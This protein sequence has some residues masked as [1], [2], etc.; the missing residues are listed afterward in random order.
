[1]S[2]LRQQLV[3]SVAEECG[4]VRAVRFDPDARSFAAYRLHGFTALAGLLDA[5]TLEAAKAEATERWS[6][7]RGDRLGI[8]E[9][10]LEEAELFPFEKQPFD[11]LHVFAVRRSEPL[12]WDFSRDLM[13]KVPVYRYSLDLICTIDLKVLGA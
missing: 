8:R 7:D 6:W 13:R 1:M 3:R 11:R 9:R 4:P 2:E 10:G 12:R 5:E